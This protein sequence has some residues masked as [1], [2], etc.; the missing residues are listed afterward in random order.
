MSQPFPTLNCILKAKNLITPMINKTP[1][2]VSKQINETLNASI[3]AKCENL[4]VGSSFKIRGAFNAVLSTPREII[5]N[6][7]ATHSSG[8][9]GQAL[10][11]AARMSNLKAL[12]IKKCP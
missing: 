11:I 8:N 4:N 10:A 2:F 12:D 3:F 9:H 1:I 7:V 6:G 5:G